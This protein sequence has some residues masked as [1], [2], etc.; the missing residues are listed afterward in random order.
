MINIFKQ[1]LFPL[2]RDPLQVHLNLTNECKSTHISNGHYKWEKR[3]IIQESEW[4]GSEFLLCCVI[5][6]KLVELLMLPSSFLKNTDKL[7]ISW[8]FYKKCFSVHKYTYS[9]CSLNVTPFHFKMF[10]FDCPLYQLWHMTA[11]HS[12]LFPESYEAIN[13]C[14]SIFLKIRNRSQYAIDL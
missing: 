10:L 12:R 14:F 8:K 9:K 2:G 7:Y 3:Y 11:H 4:T 13:L 6:G 1:L 5:L